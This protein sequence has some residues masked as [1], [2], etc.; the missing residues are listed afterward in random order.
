MK[1]KVN[2]LLNWFEAH[3]NFYIEL[4]AFLGG[5]FCILFAIFL[6]FVLLIDQSILEVSIFEYIIIPGLLGFFGV[7][8]L[9]ALR[10]TRYLT[11]KE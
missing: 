2:K 9:F 7:L 5:L 8:I 1:N 11:K 6:F 10:I 3:F 4:L